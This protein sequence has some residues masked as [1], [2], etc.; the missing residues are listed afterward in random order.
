V[1]KNTH[2][3]PNINIDDPAIRTDVQGHLLIPG[4]KPDATTSYSVVA[5]KSGYNSDAKIGLVVNDGLPYTVVQLYCQPLSNLLIRVYDSLGQ[6]AQGIQLRVTGP[7]APFLPLNGW[8]NPNPQVF[9][10][11]ADGSVIIPYIRYST[12]VDKYNIE[13]ISPGYPSLDPTT[14]VLNPGITQTINWTLPALTT[15]TTLGP[16][17]TTTLAPTTTTTQLVNLVV[18]VRRSSNNNSIS[19]ATV[20]FRGQ[21]QLTDSNGYAYFYN[22]ETGPGAL[23]VDKTNYASFSGTISLPVAGGTYNVFLV[24]L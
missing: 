6:P 14:C 23:R 8:L 24:H 15:T 13:M 16:T 4:L 5:N 11:G 7:V 1:V 20:V 19:N 9:T 10:T 2:L 18:R 12:D 22:Q 17:T 21:T 3:S